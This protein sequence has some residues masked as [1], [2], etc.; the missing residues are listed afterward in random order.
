MWIPSKRFLKNLILSPNP[1]YLVAL[2]SKAPALHIKT[3]ITAKPHKSQLIW[4][5]N[6]GVLIKILSVK[7]A[8]NMG[9]LIKTL[10]NGV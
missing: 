4:V 2:L 8:F 9:V 1:L 6:M 5:V 3:P 7:S 10:F